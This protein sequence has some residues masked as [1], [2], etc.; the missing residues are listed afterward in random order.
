MTTETAP[1]SSKGASSATSRSYDVLSLVTA[2]AELQ[3]C[4]DVGL[5]GVSLLGLQPEHFRAVE[6]K[7]KGS[8]VRCQ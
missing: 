4:L 6:E 8:R 2:T 5:E 3:H 7:A 1:K